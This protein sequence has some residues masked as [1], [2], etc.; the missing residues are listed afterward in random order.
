[1][2]RFFRKIVAFLASLFTN[3]NEWIYDHVQPSI[4]MVQRLK[5]AVESPYA[6]LITTLI[7]GNWDN[8]LQEAAIKLL[9]KAIDNLRVTEDIYFDGDWTSKIAKLTQYLRNSS[10]PM[11]GAIYHQLA[12]ELAKQSAFA[13][14][15]KEAE[16]K[17]ISTD[18]LKLDVKG[19]SISLLTQMQYSKLKENVQAADLPEVDPFLQAKISNTA[20]HYNQTV[21]RYKEL[22]PDADPAQIHSLEELNRL[23]ADAEAKA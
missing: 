8:M 11:R 21:A 2:K 16:E 7:P 13:K 10:K 5:K 20:D 6:N 22:Y 14:Q 19:H 17:G 18:Q 4:E 1:M 12:V 15:L 9:T 3:V 23:I